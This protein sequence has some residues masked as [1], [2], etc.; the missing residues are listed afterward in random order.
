MQDDIKILL[1][2]FLNKKEGRSILIRIALIIVALVIL[3]LVDYFYVSKIADKNNFLTYIDFSKGFFLEGNDPYET[4]TFNRQQEING[5]ESFSFSSPVYLLFIFLPFSYIQ[6]IT[7]ASSA[8]IFINQIIFANTIFLIIK[9]L[10]WEIA[11]IKILFF[12]LFSGFSYY[13]LINFLNLDIVIIQL[14]FFV[15]CLKAL[16]EM[17]DIEAGIFGGILSIAPGNLIVPFI[18]LIALILQK[19]RLTIFFWLIIT[20][21]FLSLG[22]IIFDTVWPLKMIRNLLGGFLNNFDASAFNLPNIL[23]GGF[24][25]LFQLIPLILMLWLVLEWGITEK[26][27]KQQILWIINISICF[28]ILIFP[29]RANLSSVLLCLVNIYIAHLW[30]DHKKKGY[31]FV[32]PLMVLIVIVMPLIANI[33]IIASGQAG[34]LEKIHLINVI[35]SV[36][37]LYWIR[38]WVMA[39]S[40]TSELDL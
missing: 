31:K 29:S 11:P 28:N 8:W 30:F 20:V 32:I 5:R 17:R 25:N 10:D 15:L 35:F 16:L 24:I 9:I 7:L 27:T 18:I 4:N 12:I 6:D 14:F 36:L 34:D 2:Y 3:A 1:D 19:K 39:G 38:W 13:S 23:E 33:E 21:A 22:A 26:K 40:F 37:L